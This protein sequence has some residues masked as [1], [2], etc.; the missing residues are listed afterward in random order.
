M[1][2]LISA[3][4]KRSDLRVLIQDSDVDSLREKTTEEIKHKHQ[5]QD[6]GFSHVAA[7]FIPQSRTELLHCSAGLQQLSL[8]VFVCVCVCPRVCVCVCEDINTL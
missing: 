4:W 7:G 1:C 3:G 5:L 8:S 2:F 6:G